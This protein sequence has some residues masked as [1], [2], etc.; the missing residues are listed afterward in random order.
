VSTTFS[1]LY[2]ELAARLNDTGYAVWTLVRMKAFINDAIAHW[3]DVGGYLEATDESTTTNATSLEYTLPAAIIDRT[4]VIEITVQGETGEPY[5][6]IADKYPE[7]IQN[8]ATVKLL[9][10]EPFA[11][12][13]TLRVRYKVPPTALSGDGDTTSVPVEFIM[14]YARYLAN[15]EAAGRPSQA[16]EKIYAQERDVALRDLNMLLPRLLARIQQP[17][18]E[19][20]RARW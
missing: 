12:G 16:N 3:W 5:A 4:R 18:R 10:D 1:T 11:A 15:G 2:A 9:V 14:L 13:K 20:T 17:Q 7:L 6:S 19:N 8:V